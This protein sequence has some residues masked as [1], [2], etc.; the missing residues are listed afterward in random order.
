[1]FILEYNKICQLE[2]IKI[3]YCNKTSRGAIIYYVTMKSAEFD[4]LPPTQVTKHQH[5]CTL[6]AKHISIY[7]HIRVNSLLQFYRK[8]YYVNKSQHDDIISG[9]SLSTTPIFIKTIT[10]NFIK[11]NLQHIISIILTLNHPLTAEKLV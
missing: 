9:S 11:N 8:N 10:Q 6:P 4:P 1:M 5:W 7:Q 3:T 2:N